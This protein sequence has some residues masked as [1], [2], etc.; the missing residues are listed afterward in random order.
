MTKRSNYI[1]RESNAQHSKMPIKYI[2]IYGERNS[3][4]NFLKQLLTKNTVDVSLLPNRWG[5]WKHGFPN[6]DRDL[7]LSRKNKTLVVFVIRDLE[8][9]L[10]SMYKNPYHYRIGGRDFAT[11]LRDSLDIYEKCP[12]SD[13]NINVNEKQD[14][15]SLRYAKI[16]YYRSIYDQLAHAV[17]VNLEDLQ[18]E[19]GLQFIQFVGKV[20]GIQTGEEFRPVL[21][22]TKCGRKRCANRTYNLVLPTDLAVDKEQEKFVSTLKE[23]YLWRSTFKTNDKENGPRERHPV[24]LL[25]QMQRST[26]VK[27]Q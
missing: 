27:T 23:N 20:Y 10:K 17:F 13:V 19:R 26:R 7:H 12:Q 9:W 5:N 6:L 24:L 16:R 1:S 4:T 3:G 21:A 2:K 22:H 11:F 15:L 14:V 25:R 8:E 18:K